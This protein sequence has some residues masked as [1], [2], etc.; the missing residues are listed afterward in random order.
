MPEGTKP[1]SE[2]GVADAFT[3]E[4]L[5]PDVSGEAEAALIDVGREPPAMG[6]H[7][8]AT[9]VL[10]VIIESAGMINGFVGVEVESA[11]TGADVAWVG[12]WT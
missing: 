11:G 10:G 4:A 7:G 12:R 3:L 8:W 9:R 2:D 5:L 1:Q 6:I